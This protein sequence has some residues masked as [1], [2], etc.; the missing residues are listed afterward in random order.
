MVHAPTISLRPCFVLVF[1]CGRCTQQGCAFGFRMA[2]LDEPAVLLGLLVHCWCYCLGSVL[3]VWRE[4]LFRVRARVHCSVPLVTVDCCM[5]CFDLLSTKHTW[6]KFSQIRTH[7]GF[8]SQT[9]TGYPS[10]GESNRPRLADF[11]SPSPPPSG[12]RCVQIKRC[13]C[14]PGSHDWSER[15]GVWECGVKVLPPPSGLVMLRHMADPRADSLEGR[16]MP[17]GSLW[18]QQHLARARHSQCRSHSWRR[19]RL[20]CRRDCR[21]PLSRR[22]SSPFRLRA[23]FQRWDSKK[24]RPTLHRRWNQR[25][26]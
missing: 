4:C 10:G 2:V 19:R 17:S 7:S 3:L 6:E 20:A 23:S 12:S 18:A 22:P 11:R 13:A 9:T 8:S 14:H 24:W 5:N 1:V 16:V 26:H 25:A 21:A 15:M